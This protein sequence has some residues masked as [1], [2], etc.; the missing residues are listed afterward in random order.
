MD[1]NLVLYCPEIPH[2]TGAIGRLCVG[3]DATLHLVRPLGFALTDARL[4]RAGLDYWP[5]L[6][7][8]VHDHW[9]AFL[10]TAQP[11]DLHVASTRGVRTHYE[12]AF[13]PG[14][15]MVFGSESTGLPADFY[16][17]YRDRLCRIPMPG[18]HVRSLNLANA[19]AVIAYEALRQMTHPKVPPFQPQCEAGTSVKVM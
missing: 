6:R 13:R 9:D 17:R 4:R 5:H 15:Y 1:L 3:L 7:L 11:G 19:A 16:E 10:A 12:C 2:N 8:Q 14:A 18:A